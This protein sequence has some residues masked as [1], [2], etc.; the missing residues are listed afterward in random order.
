MLVINLL[1]LATCMAAIFYWIHNQ[2]EIH[3]LVVFLSRLI[4]LVCI[5]V[6]SPTIIKLLLALIVFFLYHKILFISH[7]S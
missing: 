1:L 2:D 5:L 3:Q 7:K 6:L 4:A